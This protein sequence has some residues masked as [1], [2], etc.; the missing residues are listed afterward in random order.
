MARFNHHD[1][2]HASVAF[3]GD[4]GGEW[5]LD[6]LHIDGFD[7]VFEELDRF[8]GFLDGRLDGGVEEQVFMLEHCQSFPVVMS[9]ILHKPSDLS[10]WLPIKHPSMRI[11]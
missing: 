6:D 8:E 3:G 9:S 4:I 2:G 10:R 7:E 1:S 5:A 11:S